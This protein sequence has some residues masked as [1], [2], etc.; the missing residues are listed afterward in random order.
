MI[1]DFII[2]LALA[3]VLGAIIGLERELRSKEAGLRTF[4]SGRRKRAHYDYFKVW[5]SGCTLR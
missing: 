1:F 2:R 5:F 4:F 3:G